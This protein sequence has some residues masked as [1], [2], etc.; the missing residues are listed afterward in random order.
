[1]AHKYDPENTSQNFDA[2]VDLMPMFAEDCPCPEATV[3]VAERKLTLKTFFVCPQTC[4]KGSLLLRV[5][6]FTILK[7]VSVQEDRGRG[8]AVS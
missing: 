5:G 2:E 8:G 6:V 1:V 7:F 3:M 4:V